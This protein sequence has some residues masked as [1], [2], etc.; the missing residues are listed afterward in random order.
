MARRSA[1]AASVPRCLVRLASPEGLTQ[2][3]RAPR[4]A[5]PSAPRERVASRRPLRR[6][7]SSLRLKFAWLPGATRVGAPGGK[8]QGASNPRFVKN[9]LAVT[10]ALLSASSLAACNGGNLVSPTPSI[11]SQAASRSGGDAAKSGYKLLYSFKGTPD[12][13]SPYGGLIAVSGTLYGTTLNGSSNYCAQ[14][15]GSNY[16]YLGCGTVFSV[17]GSGSEHVVYNFKGNFNDA[18]DGSWPFAGMTSLNGALYGTTSSAGAHLQGTVYTVTTSGT[19]SV[20]YSFAGGTDGSV[21]EAGLTAL[22]GKLY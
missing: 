2:R 18:G 6:A 11:A 3:H 17:T 12:G 16:C 13:A 22:N 20:L 15:C 7:S 1:V 19:E 9:V 8:R 21:P 10:V 14:S 4:A 5:P